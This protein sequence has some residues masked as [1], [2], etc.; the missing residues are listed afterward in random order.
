[1]ATPSPKLKL[2]ASGMA[3]I[4]PSKT[5]N[6][7]TFI[8]GHDTYQCPWFAADF[9]SPRIGQIHSIDPTVN[10]FVIETEDPDHQ[11]EQFL[12]FGHGFG[13][14]VNETNCRF[15]LSIASELGNFELYFSLHDLVETNV[16]VAALSQHFGDWT[17]G[18]HFSDQTIE[19]LSV[20]FDGFQLCLK[21][22]TIHLID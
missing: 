1:M 20:H 11:F 21:F 9:L 2:T 3:N 4:A 6:D 22:S 19:F 14:E 10:E 18:G 15:L 7:F 12:H 13:I 17:I 5:E 8:V 16:T